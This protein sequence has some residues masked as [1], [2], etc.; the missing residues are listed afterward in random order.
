MWVSSHNALVSKNRH[1][2]HIAPCVLCLRSSGEN[3][4]GRW[5]LT[6]GSRPHT[7]LSVGIKDYSGL[8]I[9]ALRQMST[10]AEI[11]NSPQFSLLL[12]SLDEIS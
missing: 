11:R 7:A 4:P 1:P 8:A 5:N 9:D 10:F 2:S 3:D 6:S 12:N